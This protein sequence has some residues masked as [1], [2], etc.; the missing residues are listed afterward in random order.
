MRL[1]GDDGNEFMIVLILHV[2]A[3]FSCHFVQFLIFYFFFS[4]PLLYLSSMHF[5]S[6]SL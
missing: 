6:F 5:R 3:H 4:I 2:P 1:N